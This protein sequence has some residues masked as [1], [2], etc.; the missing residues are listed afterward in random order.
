MAN[1]TIIW[2]RL[3]FGKIFGGKPEVN[4]IDIP[5]TEIV[6]VNT[7]IDINGELHVVVSYMVAVVPNVEHGATAIYRGRIIRMT[8]Y[9]LLA[10]M[11]QS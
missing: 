9:P 10:G 8:D 6:P 5:V 7:V 4:F 1:I 11:N 3:E 2:E